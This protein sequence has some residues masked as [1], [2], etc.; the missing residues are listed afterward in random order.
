M[1]T[2]ISSNTI[3]SR[4]NLSI[5]IE[6]PW[7][8]LINS[9]VLGFFTNDNVAKD[10]KGYSA[11]SEIDL[12]NNAMVRIITSTGFVGN[13]MFQQNPELSFIIDSDLFFLIKKSL[14]ELDSSLNYLHDY[15]GRLIHALITE[16]LHN[17]ME[18][19]KHERI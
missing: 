10:V 16:K 4:S 19:E 3:N 13:A 9:F 17:A 2:P 18:P 7:K 12:G 6:T 11:T 8:E 14:N 15:S 1:S 5:D